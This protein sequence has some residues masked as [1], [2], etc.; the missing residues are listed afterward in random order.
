MGSNS[1]KLRETPKTFSL[2]L[3]VLLTFLFVIPTLADQINQISGNN[4]VDS[5]SSQT[6]APSEPPTEESESPSLGATA[7]SDSK[8]QSPAV[9]S[10]NSNSTS[11]A[12]ASA[13]PTP[14]PTPSPLPAEFQKFSIGIPSTIPVDPRAKTAYLPQIFLVSSSNAIL[15]MEA[16]SGRIDLIQRNQSDS[17]FSD[18]AVKISGDMSN[19]VMVTGP[20]RLIANAINNNGGLAIFN[21]VQGVANTILNF[22]LVAISQP[23][24]NASFCSAGS[25]ANSK[26]V[27][28]RGLGLTIDT[29]KGE[30]SLRSPSPRA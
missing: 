25:P 29:Q 6:P 12:T 3:A 18:G 8:E 20:T 22:K 2:I 17:F 10:P 23:S 7:A 13:S 26:V 5:N 9:D 4:A 19:F 28:I 21:Q 11:T 27:R 15:C 1:S 30:I 16:S 14:T 24:L